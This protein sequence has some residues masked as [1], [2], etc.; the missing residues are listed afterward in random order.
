VLRGAARLRFKF[1]FTTAAYGLIRLPKL[2]GASAWM[3]SGPAAVIGL[4]SL[5]RKSPCRRNKFKYPLSGAAF[6]LC[7]AATDRP[8]VA[9]SSYAGQKS[10]G[11]LVAIVLYGGSSNPVDSAV[12][13]IA[14]HRFQTH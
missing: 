11:L 5:R 9:A 13:P 4:T 14:K 8:R 12:K 3:E 7:R 6:F 1:T 10:E 2:R